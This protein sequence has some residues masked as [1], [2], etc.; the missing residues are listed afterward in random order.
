HGCPW[1]QKPSEKATVMLEYAALMNALNSGD[2][3]PGQMASVIGKD[4]TDAL[5]QAALSVAQTTAGGRI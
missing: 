3:T 2:I 1:I 5:R 4:N